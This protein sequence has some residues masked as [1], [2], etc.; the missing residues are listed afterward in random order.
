ME[1]K[2]HIRKQ[3]VEIAFHH[4]GDG[5][6]LRN[7]L[8][9][10]CKY[11]L[12]A[13]LEKVFDE[14][15]LDG[16]VL[17]LDKLVI[18]AGELNA[19]NWEEEL[20]QHVMQQ[21]HECIDAAVPI[22]VQA[23]E[24]SA[25]V[26]EEKE[27]SIHTLLHFLETGML[28]WHASVKT[29]AALESGVDDWITRKDI[30]FLKE[31]KEVLL[32]SES[33]LL[34]FVNHF[35]EATVRTLI[36][37][38]SKKK[39]LPDE[40]KNFWQTVLAE[41][42]FSAPKQAEI[43]LTAELKSVLQSEGNIEKGFATNI[44]HQLST[45]E[46]KALIPLLLKQ[47]RVEETREHSE[48]KKTQHQL[49][50]KQIHQEET[51]QHDLPPNQL[52]SEKMKTKRQSLQKQ[53][54]Q[55]EIEQHDLPLNQ[56]HSGKR[57]TL[58]QSHLEQKQQEEAKLA[59]HLLQLKKEIAGRLQE[60]NGKS[61]DD[62]GATKKENEPAQIEKQ[63]PSRKI[64]D[65]EGWYINNAGL[66]LL[67]PFITPLFEN[68]GYTEK[69]KWT[70]SEVQERAVLLTQFMG[71][72][73]EEFAEFDLLLNKILCG[74]EI[75]EPIPVNIL[76]S[77]FEKEEA[78]DV[79]KSV[80]KHWQA[81]KNTSV[82]GLQS[83]FLIRDGKITDDSTRYLLQVEQKSFDVLMNRLPWGLGTIRLPW[84]RQLL[85]VEWT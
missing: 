62:S 24:K 85:N 13:A 79:L 46:K 43:L 41:L 27:N 2:H 71:S 35:S 7:R 73:N 60:E 33:A 52:Y 19:A 76:L 45:E 36:R 12:P 29:K 28:P 63:K 47:D 84:M 59:D 54:Q 38:F 20:V 37:E 9:E 6:N 4:S 57:K 51:K 58:E 56:E 40:W 78:T 74:V 83:T 64:Y 66:V 42:G 32:K 21:L 30:S 31:L 14:K 82:A 69:H 70:N 81:L 23:T 18:N 11:K 10:V 1:A 16:K 53:K 17:R 68:L 3:T 72:G 5:M 49:H 61:L 15:I 50:L 48:K 39:S 77:D 44:F 80:I 8:S 67:H 55:E 25:V 26:M 65:E 75:E 34:R 22:N